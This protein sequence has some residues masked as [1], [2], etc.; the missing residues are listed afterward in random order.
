MVDKATQTVYALDVTSKSSQILGA[1]NMHDVAIHGT[2][3]YVLTDSGINEI[4]LTNKQTVANVVTK[5]SQW[6]TIGALVSFG[7]NL[8][9]LDTKESRIWKYVATDTGFSELREYLNPDT[10]P[11]LSRANSMAIDGSVWIGTADG[12]IIKFTQGKVD[13]FIPQGVD[14]AF[15]QNLA[16]YTS[17][18]TTNF[19]VLDG[20]N[21]RVVVLQKDGTYLAQYVW[22]DAIIPT[23]LAVSETQKKIY[24]L[25]SGQLYAIDLK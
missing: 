12:N 24:L 8:Y 20:Q 19:Y 17:D 6:G 13:T 10:L 21:K 3:L 23:Q 1:G 11:D 22:K 9:L 16:V 25:A 14:P 18:A 4:Q 2:N 5:D 15:G 7:G